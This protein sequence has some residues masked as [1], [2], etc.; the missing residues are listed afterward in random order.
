MH[1]LMLNFV[2]FTDAVKFDSLN[3]VL[4]PVVMISN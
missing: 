1:D 2:I 3:S 4:S